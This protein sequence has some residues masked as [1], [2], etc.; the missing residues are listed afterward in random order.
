VLPLGF[1]VGG[2]G[3]VPVPVPP[4]LVPPLPPVLPLGFVVGGD[5]VEVVPLL[6]S[7]VLPLGLVVGLLDPDVVVV[8]PPEP[9]WLDPLGRVVAGAV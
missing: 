9:L 4:S 6:L 2:V 7:L 3:V 8:P 5:G 1:V